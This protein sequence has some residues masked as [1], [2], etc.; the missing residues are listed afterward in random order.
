MSDLLQ[1]CDWQLHLKQLYY[2]CMSLNI[3]MPGDWLGH[4]S[5]LAWFR[6]LSEVLW[7]YVWLKPFPLSWLMRLSVPL[8]S[9]YILPFIC[10]SMTCNTHV[11]FAE[12]QTCILMLLSLYFTVGMMVIMWTT[13]HLTAIWMIAITVWLKYCQRTTSLFLTFLIINL[14]EFLHGAPIQA[15]YLWLHYFF[16]QFKC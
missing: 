2:I 3:V 13:V 12:K 11:L 9:K 8:I 6:T 10:P 7:L 15:K 14:K 1:S 5:T 4:K 16:F